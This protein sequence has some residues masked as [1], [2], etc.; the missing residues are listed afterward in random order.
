MKDTKKRFL[1]AAFALALPLTLAGCG[2]AAQSAET[3]RSAA[4]VQSTAS[5]A[6]LASSAPVVSAAASDPEDTGKTAQGS[7]SVTAAEGGKVTQSGSVWTI[8][9]AGTYTLTGALADGQI[10]V[11]AGDE[12]VVELILDNAAI[13]CTAGA[14]ILVLNADDVTVKAAEGS[15]NTVADL[16]TGDAEAEEYDAAIWSDCDL[17]LRGKGTLIVT[18]DFAKGVKST[19][20][21][22]VRNLT[23][24]VDSADTALRGKVSVTVESGE[25]LL[26][27][28]HGDGVSS[29]GDVLIS[30]GAVTIQVGDDGIHADGSLTIAGG[31]VNIPESHEGLE[32]NVIHIDGGSTYVY[33]SDDGVNARRGESTPLVAV[34][35]G[36][37]EVVTSGGDTDAIDSN[38]DFT[39]SGGFVLARGGAAMGGM[40]G[41]VDCDGSV[42]V[43]GGTIIALGGVCSVPGSGSVNTWISGT[44]ALGAGDYTLSDSQGNEIAAFTLDGSY[45]GAWIASDAIELGETYTLSCNGSAAASWT[46]QSATE[47]S[48]PFGGMGGFG[49]G[50]GGMGGFGG[51][52]PAGEAGELPSGERPELPAGEAG[53]RPS[54]ELPG[55]CGGGERPTMPIDG[56]TPLFGPG[57][58]A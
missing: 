40:A 37:L 12:D 47:G 50:K 2:A 19:D 35:G 28:A 52:Q 21:L 32:A 49:G 5:A 58:S 4:S 53:E 3:A 16:R 8:T 22:S 11:D 31:T 46:Q 25:I 10:V 13:S 41:S 17:K 9:A 51:Q 34:T 1:A 23:L 38:G 43:T 7:F 24:K 56:Q 54:G 33:G 15:Y 27:S 55:R 45:S 29:E 44:T 26:L 18:G 48:A 39:M 6:V 57:L 14:P 30:D 20:D 42:T 36:Y